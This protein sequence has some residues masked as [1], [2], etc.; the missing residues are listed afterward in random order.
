MATG[1]DS[2]VVATTSVTRVAYTADASGVVH[3]PLGKA[4]P[5]MLRSA[6]ASR[7]VNGAANEW[8]VSRTTYVFTVGTK[9]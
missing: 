7:K 5:V 3:L 1:L 4:G 6:Y 2:A 9:H 8:D